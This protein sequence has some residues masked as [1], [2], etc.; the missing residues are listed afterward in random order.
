MTGPAMSE[1]GTAG[2]DLIMNPKSLTY[3]SIGSNA[4]DLTSMGSSLG[5]GVGVGRW[6]ITK[7]EPL[8][9][10]IAAR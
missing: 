9:S 7:G 5:P 4:I 8:D 2:Q 3:E 10:R 6:V 1:P